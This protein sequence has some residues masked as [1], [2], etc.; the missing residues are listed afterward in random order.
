M[1]AT[2]LTKLQKYTVEFRQPTANL[3]HLLEAAN[4]LVLQKTKK[5]KL[6]YQVK[7][8]KWGG[9]GGEHQLIRGAFHAVCK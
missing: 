2:R 9:G 1:N 3:D 4:L 7:P 6:G 5:Q 8:K